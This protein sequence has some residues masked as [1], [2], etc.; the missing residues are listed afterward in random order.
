MRRAAVV[1]MRRLT[2]FMAV[3]A[4][5]FPLPTAKEITPPTA[6]IVSGM[7]GSALH[8]TDV[9]TGGRYGFHDVQCR[10]IVAG[11]AWACTVYAKAIPRHLILFGGVTWSRGAGFH[12]GQG[13]QL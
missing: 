6:A 10:T 11:H 2:A 12:I 5:T 3:A 9:G 13:V 8:R 4:L 1:D 7:L